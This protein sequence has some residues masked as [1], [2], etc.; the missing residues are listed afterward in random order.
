MSLLKWEELAKKKTELGNTIN[1][2][3]DTKQAKKLFKKYSN[4]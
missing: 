2:V 1:F 4:Q 3:H